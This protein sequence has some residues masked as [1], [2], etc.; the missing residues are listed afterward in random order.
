MQV[1]LGRG[2]T[3]IIGCQIG[4][5]T[6]ALER[7]LPPQARGR[8]FRSTKLTVTLVRKENGKKKSKKKGKGD[9]V[10]EGT[11]WCNPLDQFCRKTGRIYAM[12]RLFARNRKKKL[13]SRKECRLVSAAIL[14]L[15]KGPNDE[16]RA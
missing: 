14:G 3:A 13:L 11:S 4:E 15:G 7:P 10:I 2:R 16:E 9:D 8:S 12:R 6:P 1:E 5:A